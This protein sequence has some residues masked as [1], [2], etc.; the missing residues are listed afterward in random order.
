M[1]L[2]ATNATEWTFGLSETLFK[3][4]RDRA[5]YVGGLNDDGKTAYDAAAG[6]LQTIQGIVYNDA[7]IV[8][9]E[10]GYYRLHNLP[11]TDGITTPRYMS[12]YLHEIEKTYNGGNPMHFYSRKGVNNNTFESLES[13]YTVSPATQGSIPIP[14]TEYDPSSIFYHLIRPPL[15][16][17]RP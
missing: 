16:P 9:Y 5:G 15:R 10:S 4:Y 1:T 12:G 2:S 6:N 14:A 17:D 8:S 7:N 3:P 13:G 11:N